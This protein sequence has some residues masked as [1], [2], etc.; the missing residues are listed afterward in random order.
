MKIGSKVRCIN[1]RNYGA[2]EEGKE[3]TVKDVDGCVDLLLHGA[4]VGHYYDKRDFEL[5]E[6]KNELPMLTLQFGEGNAVTVNPNV[7]FSRKFAEAFLD[8]VYGKE[9]A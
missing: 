1:A 6:D 4:A 2:V 8:A 7:P 5:V 9:V 3:Y